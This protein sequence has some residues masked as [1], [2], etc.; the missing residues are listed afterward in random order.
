MG[1]SYLTKSRHF[2]NSK[3]IRKIGRNIEFGV[4]GSPDFDAV[5]ILSGHGFDMHTMRVADELLLFF[6][7]PSFRFYKNIQLSCSNTSNAMYL[8]QSTDP[9]DG[10]VLQYMPPNSCTS[11]HYHKMRTEVY[12]SLAG[13]CLLY[14][15][16]EIS[17]VNGNSKIIPPD[18]VHQLWTGSS[19][20]IIL[21]EMQDDQKGIS[22]DDHFYVE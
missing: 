15:D 21:L 16:D 2:L 7:Q 5:E 8:G 13:K 6:H 14:A 22:L 10:L 20:S 18:T 3:S 11:R 1:I 9:L 4:L 19:P 17:R 12:H